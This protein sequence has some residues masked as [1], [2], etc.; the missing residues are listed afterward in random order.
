MTPIQYV[1]THWKKKT[2]AMMIKDSGFNKHCIESAFEELGLEPV[3]DYEV[4]VEE[5]RYSI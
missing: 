3:G 5:R 2:V 1:K 4:R